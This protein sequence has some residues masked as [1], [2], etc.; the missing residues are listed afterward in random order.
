MRTPGKK[1]KSKQP[2]EITETQRV[3]LRGVHA[4][5]QKLDRVPSTVE[6]AAHLDY[7]DHT[8]VLRPLKALVR[9]KLAAPVTRTLIFGYELTPAGR[10]LL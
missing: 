8:G 5:K 4:L 2:S 1:S 10:K 3:V 7:A 6:L 9:L